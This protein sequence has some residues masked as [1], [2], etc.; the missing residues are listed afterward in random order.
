MREF[1]FSLKKEIVGGLRP[2]DR[3][4]RNS[5][6]LTKCQGIRPAILPGGSRDL[7]KYTAPTS[8]FAAGYLAG[9][10][11]SL[12]FPFPQLI[13]GRESSWLADDTTLY[14]ATE[15]ANWTIASVTTYDAYAPG[16]AK[17][18][19]TGNAWHIADFGK[20]YAL[21]NGSCIVFKRFS[22]GMFGNTDPTLVVDDITVQTGCAFNGR[23]V[24]GG[25]STTDFFN[26]AWENFLRDKFDLGF[27]MTFP[28]MLGTNFVWWSPVGSDAFW[29]IYPE[30][31]LLGLVSEGDNIPHTW[32]KTKL[33][34]LMESGGMGFM[35]MQWQGNVL[36]TKPLGKGM[37]VYGDNGISYM[38]LTQVDGV[39]T[40]GLQEVL[41][42]GVANRSAV[43]SN[44]MGTEHVFLD[45]A[46]WLRRVKIGEQ[47]ENLGYREY[48]ENMLDASDIVITH[49]PIEE[50]YYI[51][52]GSETFV[53]TK[54]GLFEVNDLPTSVLASLGGTVWVAD[55]VGDADDAYA[56][57]VT[58]VFNMQLNMLKTI[59]RV[60]V[61]CTNT[62]DVSV[63]IDWRYKTSDS[64]TR[65]L[66]SDINDEGEAHFPVSGIEFRMVVRCLTLTTLDIDDIIVHFKTTDKRE[67]RGTYALENV[68]RSNR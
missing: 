50:D 56:I 36:N 2:D 38:P 22:E 51:S 11:V 37:M 41:P 32:D 43:G 18:I 23:M 48:F 9:Q 53:L 8:P 64:W 33:L 66:Y 62:T 3:Q 24:M 47:V 34:E 45:E 31:T 10:G 46:G 30:D 14:T 25:F 16:T 44:M 21:F 17:A 15:G 4:P 28:D 49:D 6:F 13:K 26:N 55:A 20:T 54:G 58:D 40:F 57:L 42:I 39:S 52:D 35:P 7:T 63:A 1:S 12:S 61:H 29:V 27:G 5:G 65:T 59:E 19:T 68:A 67:L 60:S